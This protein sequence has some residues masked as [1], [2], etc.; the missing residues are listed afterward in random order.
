MFILEVILYLILISILVFVIYCLELPTFR[1]AIYFPTKPHNVDLMIGLAKLRPG[2]HVADIGSGDGRI[3]IACAKLGIY[4]TGYEINP[5][6]VFSSRRAVRK[7]GLQKYAA[8]HW[9]S[10]WKADLSKYDAIFVYGIPY[11]MKR[12]ERKLMRESKPGA[13]IISNIFK[14][15]NW[16]PVK[17][18]EGKVHLYVLNDSHLVSQIQK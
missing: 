18:E 11:I 8:I 17:S 10:L 9:K 16:Q 1:G 5:V 15:P 13:K 12:L 3:V 7:A 2:D 6:L 4:A 14:F